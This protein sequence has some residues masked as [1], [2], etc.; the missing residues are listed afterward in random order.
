MGLLSKAAKAA[1]ELY[2]PKVNGTTVATELFPFGFAPHPTSYH[3]RLRTDQFFPVDEYAN[4]HLGER[5]WPDVTM[6]PV[7]E[8]IGTQG[9]IHPGFLD[10]ANKN[11]LT[12]FLDEEG[13][14]LIINGH[15]R[16]ARAIA[17]GDREVPARVFSGREN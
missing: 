9:A 7:D 11:P 12:V 17:R 10:R 8:L 1:R 4:Y 3:P 6:I 5:A 15:H 14:K 2:R 16:V 13:R